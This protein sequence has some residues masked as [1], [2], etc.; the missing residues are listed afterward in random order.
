MNIT[1]L[2]NEKKKYTVSIQTTGCTIESM[3]ALKYYSSVLFIFNLAFTGVL[4]QLT[5]CVSYCNIHT[6][7]I[8]I[9]RNDKKMYWFKLQVD[10]EQNCLKDITFLFIFEVLIWKL[11]YFINDLNGQATSHSCNIQAVNLPIISTECKNIHTNQTTGF[12]KVNR[13]A[14]KYYTPFYF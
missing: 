2:Q 8:P 7:A 4:P 3:D 11:P 1:I 9:L 14:L 6:V 5:G 13:D 10:K 12:T